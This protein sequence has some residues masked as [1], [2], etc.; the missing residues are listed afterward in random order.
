MHVL[1]YGDVEL[2]IVSYIRGCYDG[3]CII[4]EQLRRS[5]AKNRKDNDEP[6]DDTFCRLSAVE[7]VN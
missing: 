5:G 1:V 7:R 4:L 2:P 3:R 6:F